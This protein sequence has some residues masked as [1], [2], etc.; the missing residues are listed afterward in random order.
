MEQNNAQSD[1]EF[2]KKIISDSKRV[3]EADGKTFIFWGILVAIGLL[4]TYF[5]ANSSYGNITGWLW[6]GLILF[7]WL[8]TFITE[9]KTAK[10]QRAITFASKI[11][12][13]TWISLGL[14]MTIIAFIGPISGAFSPIYTSPI[15]S[16]ILGIGYI[17]SGVVLGKKW[18]SF[19]AAGWWIGAIAMFF[20]ANMETLIVMAFMM[21]LFQ[22]IPG[23]I[24]F[25]EIVSTEQ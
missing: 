15:L 2:I 5:F 14:A 1:L 20:M 25:K 19:L 12:A 11:L 16:V 17:V 10:K 4:L 9:K 23:I 3:V 8:Y 6:I 7:G 13:A 18:F 24:L 21:I 22:T